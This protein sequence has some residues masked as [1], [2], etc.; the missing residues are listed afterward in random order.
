MDPHLRLTLAAADLAP[1]RAALLAMA[2]HPR[3]RRSRATTTYYDTQDHALRRRGLTLEVRR[4]GRQYLQTVSRDPD[5]DP[6]PV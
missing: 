6:V 4:I 1:A 2:G 3:A 5:G